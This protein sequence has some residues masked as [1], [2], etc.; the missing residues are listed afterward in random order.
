MQVI[1]KM[2]K[3]IMIKVIKKEHQ[4]DYDGQCDKYDND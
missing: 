3:T 2:K 4:S 1:N